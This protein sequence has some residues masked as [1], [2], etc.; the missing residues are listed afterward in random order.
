MNSLPQVY[1]FPWENI[2]AQGQDAKGS[3]AADW[4]TSRSLTALK[5]AEE[6][7]KDVPGT[8]VVAVRFE[9]RA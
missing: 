9:T 4:A 8:T 7:S 5:K 1:L 6:S 3:D 2:A